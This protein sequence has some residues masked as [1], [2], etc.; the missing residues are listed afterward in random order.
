MSGTCLPLCTASST[1]STRWRHHWQL[2]WSWP[3]TWCAA[4]SISLAS[5]ASSLRPT[6]SRLLGTSDPWQEASAITFG[7]HGV[8]FYGSGPFDNPTRVI[9]NLISSVGEGN[10]QYIAHIGAAASW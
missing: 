7:R 3:A 4:Q 10:F 6:S 5:S 1:L 8:P 9:R 2:R